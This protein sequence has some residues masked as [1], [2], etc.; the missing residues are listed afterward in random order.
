MTSSPWRPQPALPPRYAR[1]T[2]RYVS[3]W[4]VPPRARR[5]P[6]WRASSRRRHPG[7]PGRQDVWSKQIVRIPRTT[8]A[9]RR[10]RRPPVPAHGVHDPPRHAPDPEFSCRCAAPRANSADRAVGGPV[11]RV[12]VGQADQVYKKALGTVKCVSGAPV[13][14]GRAGRS[15]T[16]STLCRACRA[17]AAR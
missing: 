12:R 17:T 9:A 6:S 1:S 15:S 2:E 3:R 13:G 16:S 4:P 5:C 10:D 14:L 8:Y 7:R 11:G